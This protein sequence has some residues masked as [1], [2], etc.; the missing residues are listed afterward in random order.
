VLFGLPACAFFTAIVATLVGTFGWEHGA[1][2]SIF[3]ALGLATP[4]LYE[5]PSTP[6]LEWPTWI[7]YSAIPLGSAL[8]SYRFLQVAWSF[9]KTGELPKH[10]HGHVEGL[11][12]EVQ[13]PVTAFAP[14]SHTKGTP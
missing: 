4:D 9:F 12:A 1:H 10:D 5:G 3:T 11:E 14:A 13:D 2:Y 8:M 6:D 7:V